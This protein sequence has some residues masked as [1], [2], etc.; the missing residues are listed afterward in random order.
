MNGLEPLACWLQ[1]SCS[2][3]SY[4]AIYH[5]FLGRGCFEIGLHGWGTLP[6]G[7]SFDEG[8]VSDSI[9]TA[10]TIPVFTARYPGIPQSPVYPQKKFFR[11][12]VWLNY[13]ENPYL[14][15]SCIPVLLVIVGISTFLAVLWS[16]S[17]S[18]ACSVILLYAV[19]IRC[20]FMFWG[21]SSGYSDTFIQTNVCLYFTLSAR[22]LPLL[23][24]ASTAV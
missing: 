6:T 19:N 20:L 24:L 13:S 7:L 3:L 10:W 22:R 11:V 18:Y 15:N 5:L 9:L 12:Y 4:T 1:I 17:P 2:T 23:A 16:V 14:R 21:I 8:V